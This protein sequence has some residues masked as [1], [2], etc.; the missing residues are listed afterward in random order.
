[1]LKGPIAAA[2]YSEDVR[3]LRAEMEEINKRQMQ[4]TQFVNRVMGVLQTLGQIIGGSIEGSNRAKGRS[5][6]PT[7]AVCGQE[8]RDQ[9]SRIPETLV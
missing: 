4:V 7:R 8:I 5:G 9:P 2:N 6:M 1:V 3:S